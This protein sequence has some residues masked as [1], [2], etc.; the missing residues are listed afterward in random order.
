MKTGPLLGK[1]GS[2]VK[3]ILPSGK[4]LA[5][6][7]Q[8]ASLRSLSYP[9]ILLCMRVLGKMVASFESV[10]FVQFLSRPLQWNNLMVWNKRIQSL[11]FPMSSHPSTLRS[12]DW[13]MSPQQLEAGKSLYP[14]SW[15]TL[16]MD[17][18]FSGGGG[19]RED[20]DHLSV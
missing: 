2:Q 3:V 9:S 5:L 17:P 10:P 8:V 1:V 15:M 7:N 19:D 6:R 4:C 16:M 12:L 11:D 14:L 13:W 20:L 18:S